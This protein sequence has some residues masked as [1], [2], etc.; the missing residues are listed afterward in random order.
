MSEEGDKWKLPSEVF[1]EDLALN[2][3]LSLPH[4]QYVS[5]YMIQSL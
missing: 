3:G 2:Y 1:V 4:E 5:N